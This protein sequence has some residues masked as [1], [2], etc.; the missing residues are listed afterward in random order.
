MTE[1][2][3]SL[4]TRWFEEVWNKGRRESE[5]RRNVRAGWRAARGRNEAVGPEG[6]YLFF[7]QLEPGAIGVPGYGS[8]TIAEGDQACV[9]WSCSC[10]GTG[11]GLGMPATQKT[12]HVTGISIIRIADNRGRGLAR[13]GTCWEYWSEF[14]SR[15]DPPLM[16]VRAERSGTCYSAHSVSTGSTAAAQQSRD[17][18]PTPWLRPKTRGHCGVSRVGR[19][20]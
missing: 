6:F 16:S 17:N 10:K 18:W 15:K 1:L 4:G 5:N 11:D 20:G 8:D 7:D 19:S 3:R 12:V 14:V 2:D 9:R 13:I